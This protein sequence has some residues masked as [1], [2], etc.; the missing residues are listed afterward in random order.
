MNKVIM[1]GRVGADIVLKKVGKDNTPFVEFSL[2]TTDYWRDKTTGEK[3]ERTEWIK[4]RA[5]RKEAENAAA[6]VIKGQMVMVE[7]KWRV[8]IFKRN[9]QAEKNEYYNYLEA[10]HIEYHE[11]PR[12]WWEKTLTG[13]VQTAKP[14]APAAAKNPGLT[15]AIDDAVLE[16]KIMALF[17]KLMGAGA[18]QNLS[19]GPQVLVIDDTPESGAEIE[20]ET[21]YPPESEQYHDLP[22]YPEGAPHTA[23]APPAQ[24]RKLDARL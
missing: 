13:A 2:G 3:K 1:T 15:K 22:Y 6:Y 9:P 23:V 7:G 20:E 16:Q 4:V 8:S 12:A 11:K 17:S 14:Q 24:E 19:V 18:P 21:F 5:W 10:S